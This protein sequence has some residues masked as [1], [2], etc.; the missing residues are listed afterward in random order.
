MAYYLQ[1]LGVPYDLFEAS[2]SVGGLIQS[3]LKIAYQLELGPSFLQMTEEMEELLLEL[4]LQDQVIPPVST[5]QHGYLWKENTL[6]ALPFTPQEA[7]QLPFL[8]EQTRQLLT[9]EEQ[10]GPDHTSCETVS[11][12]F[13]KRYGQEVLDYLVKPL[14][15]GFHGGDADV[16]LVEK[17][18]PVVK[19]L[20]QTYGSLSRGLAQAPHTFR[21]QIFALREGLQTLPEAIASKLISLHL[22]HRVEMVHRTRGKY[23]LSIAHDLE[24]LSD[25]EYDAVVMALPAQP[26]AELLNY[27]APGM[28][29]ALLNVN[30][31]SMTVV[32]TVYR[33]TDVTQELEGLGALHS[34]KENMFSLGSFWTSCVFPHCSP[35]NEV[36]FTT[37]VC[38]DSINTAG[39]LARTEILERVHQELKQQYAITADTPVFQHLH[40]WPQAI[41]QADVFIQDV[42]EMV[43]ALEQEQL[44]GCTNWLAGPSVS[45]CV[46]YAKNLAQKIYSQ[47][48]SIL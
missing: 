32:H 9:Q 39:Q 13:R 17:T 42:H 10:P 8:A 16:L 48:S 38:C 7:L 5:A 40:A 45:A 44:Y 4:K 24:S 41:P 1:K 12:Y 15:A 22:E 28:A 36:M 6:Y 31:A 34:S 23:F 43:A 21:K 46:R 11:Q 14:V 35:R 27:V 20:E 25:E 29:A 26:A 30:Y 3:T 18:L 2:A 19:E 33:Q 37:L 47:R